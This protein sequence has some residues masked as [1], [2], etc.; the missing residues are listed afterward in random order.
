MYNKTKKNKF[1]LTI[2]SSQNKRTLLQKSEYSKYCS[3]DFDL[4]FDFNFDLFPDLF[5]NYELLEVCSCI[6]VCSDPSFNCELLEVCSCVFVRSDPSFNC[7]LLEVYSC[8]F[9][10]NLSFD[11]DL[12][13]RCLT[14]YIK[15][16]GTTSLKG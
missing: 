3:F 12:F 8:V 10:F 4:L 5:F 16:S 9:N 7:E 14:S 15:Y 2:N 13:K 11:P 1:S 6:F